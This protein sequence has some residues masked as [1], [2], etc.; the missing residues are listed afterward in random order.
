MTKT[1]VKKE[2]TKEDIE[3]TIEELTKKG[4]T[5][6]DIGLYI[7]ENLNIKNIH[8]FCGEK[9]IDI[10]RRLKLKE[11]KLP[12]DLLDLIN[13]AVKLLKHRDKNKK[14]TRAL[15]GYQI[16]VSKINRL[17][18]YYIKKGT[19]PKNWRYS[20]DTAKLLTK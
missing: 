20:E 19:I 17:R 18:N 4:K 7:K 9:I 3:K 12:D 8:A 10:Q 16:T 6:A 13:K 5:N 14:D 2:V 1:E 15:R 11:N